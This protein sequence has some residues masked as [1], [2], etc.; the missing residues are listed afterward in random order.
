MR[1]GTKSRSP[2]RMRSLAAPEARLHRARVAREV[3]GGD[4]ASGEQA[5]LDGGPD[6]FA[7]LRPRQARAV[8]DEHEAIAR[9]RPA[10]LAVEHVGVPVPLRR[11]ARR[12]LAE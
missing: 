2:G 11:R 10:R 1:R 4:R 9:E 3:A 7:A 6:A 5:G 8:A 12:Q